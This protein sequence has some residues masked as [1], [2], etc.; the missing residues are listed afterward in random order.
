MRFSLDQLQ[1]FALV[2]E[3]GSFSAA[4]RRLGKTQSTVSAAVANLEIDLGVPLFDR[5]SRNPALTEAGRKLLTEAEAVLE[6]CLSLQAH[7]ASLADANPPGLSLAIEIPYHAVMPVLAEFEREF[8][9]VDLTIR[10]PVYGDVSEL[11]LQGQAELGIAFAQPHYAPE[12]AFVQLGKLIMVHVV[13]PG[14]ALAGREQ[15]SF[16]DLHAYRRLAFSAHA[17]KLPTS[18]YL[19]AARVWRAESYLALVEMVKSGLG[20]ATLPRQLVREALERGELVELD[21]AA[22]PYTDW[23]VSVDL[24]WAKSGRPQGR[25]EQWLRQRFRENMVFEVDRRGQRTIR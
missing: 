23:L 4:A 24:I 13:H 18:E 14:H 22:Y 15:V 19:R 1:V 25:A 5:S 9:Y 3:T 12:L 8:P 2:V 20:W 16:A 17:D 21:L 11:V 6:R 7:A 10:N